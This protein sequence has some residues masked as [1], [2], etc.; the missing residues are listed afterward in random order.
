MS[1]IAHSAKIITNVLQKLSI[2]RAAQIMEIYNAVEEMDE[3]EEEDAEAP[4]TS[5]GHRLRQRSVE[6]VLDRDAW[7]KKCK[8]LLNYN[9]SA[10]TRSPSGQ[11]VNP[12]NY[13]D[14]LNIID[15]PMDFSTVRRTLGEDRYENPTELSYTPNKRSKI[16]SM[17]LRLLAFFEEQIRAITSEYK[18]AIKSSDRLRRSQ[19]CR[20][21]MQPHDQSTSSQKRAAAKTQEK[22]ES[23]SVTKSTSA[24]VGVPDRA[25]RSRR[26]SSSD[27]SKVLHQP[28]SLTV[29]A[30]RVSRRRRNVLAP[31]G[32][33]RLRTQS[34]SYEKQP[35]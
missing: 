7:K 22:V 17:T 4:G 19:R 33:H 35:G 14:Y 6:V 2:I 13:P 21:K 16:Y 29:R 9:L 26:R 31:R 20:K 18:T 24:K 30:S 32:H 12:Q 34:Q 3:D 8:N 23:A 25:R 15:T 5:S 1:K 10:R 27:D 28:Q 11:P